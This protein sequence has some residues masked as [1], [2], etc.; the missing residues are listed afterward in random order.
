MI[1]TPSPFR[2]LTT[3]PNLHRSLLALAVLSLMCCLA[4][5]GPGASPLEL[6]ASKT[7]TPTLTPTPNATATPTLT[8]TITPTPTAT[9]VL[10]A[11]LEPVQTLMIGGDV[12]EIDWS[13]DGQRL[14]VLPYSGTGQVWHLTQPDSF[15]PLDTR[16]GVW[17]PDG[18]YLAAERYDEVIIMDSATYQHINAWVGDFSV[19]DLDWMPDSKSLV[20]TTGRQGSVRVYSVETGGEIDAVVT[21][22]AWGDIFLTELSPN[23]RYLAVLGDDLHLWDL[24]QHQEIAVIPDGHTFTWASDDM[25]YADTYD[26]VC[27]FDRA[28]G[29]R[30]IGLPALPVLLTSAIGPRMLDVSPDGRLLTG[31][32]DTSFVYRDWLRPEFLTRYDVEE[33]MVTL[34]FSPDGKYLAVGGDDQMVTIYSIEFVP[35]KYP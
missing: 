32:S 33:N 28:T 24:E 9:P 15:M 1:Q 18:K 27:A 8:P 35:P 14:Y 26:G 3:R 22:G 10:R 4:G 6:F 17:S 11:N 7:P 2:S 31:V 30:E 21:S 5:C 25:I 29:T 34:Q 23:G 19:I 16:Y 20:V 12:W 13:P